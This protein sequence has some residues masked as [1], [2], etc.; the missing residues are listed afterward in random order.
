MRNVLFVY[1][2]LQMGG[3]E[4]LYSRIAKS[5]A[6]RCKFLFLC[7][8]QDC[9]DELLRELALNAN[10]YF[11]SELL[12]STKAK[13]AVNKPIPVK[14]L[15]G[16]DK[17]ALYRIGSID[18]V[19]VTEGL[20]ILLAHQLLKKLNLDVPITVGLYHQK[21]FIWGDIN[22]LPYFER[23]NRKVFELLPSE[24]ILFFNE[25][26]FESYTKRLHGGLDRAKLFPLGV[27]FDS[28]AVP[29]V[30]CSGS[31]LRIVSIGRLTDFK[32]YNLWMIDVVADLISKGYDVKYDI[33]GDG[34]VRKTIENKLSA[35][36]DLPIEL[37]GTLAY[38]EF[39]STLSGYDIFVG[40]GTAIVEAAANGIPSII[41][42]ESI[43]K[44][45]SYG[46]FSNIPG[47][48]YNEQGL[49]LPT[50]EV[51]VLIEDF[52]NS[53]VGSRENLQAK[54]VEKARLFSMQHCIAN[55]GEAFKGAAVQKSFANLYSD[56]Y[57][58]SYLFTAIKSKLFKTSYSRKY[59]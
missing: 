19:H 41:G 28:S 6:F 37:K 8:K 29:P 52:I 43:E 18:V 1:R 16:L 39:K 13:L 23:V 45:I 40:S 32:T 5:S 33:Y 56:K 7:E 48:S 49:S 9:N 24:N 58:I 3:I 44:P 17:Q 4:T 53:E 21:E 27:D 42:I 26:V 35:R 54:H 50:Y 51:S 55:F 38:S 11:Y 36:R 22:R 14:L 59:K 31:T 15:F 30:V 20:G 25:S 2:G 34:P 47:F 46:F 10:V 57:L 12:S